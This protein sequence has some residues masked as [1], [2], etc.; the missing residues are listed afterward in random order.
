MLNLIWTFV[1]G[2]VVGLIARWIMPGAHAMGLIM[3]GALGIVGSLVGGFIANLFTDS[4]N[5]PFHPAGMLMSILGAIIV[6]WVAQL[7]HR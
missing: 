4:K 5:K 1:V 7:L 6:L 2:I 3:T